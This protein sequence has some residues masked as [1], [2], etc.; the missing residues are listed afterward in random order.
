MIDLKAALSSFSKVEQR[1]IAYFLSR[2]FKGSPYLE[3]DGK[4]I[5][6]DVFDEPVELHI[7]KATE[8]TIKAIEADV[9]SAT[10]FDEATAQL[11]LDYV[12]EFEDSLAEQPT[13][14]ERS[15][16]DSFLKSAIPPEFRR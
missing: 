9:G 3:Q 16:A 6:L 10:A 15:E 1:E 4:D 8:S 5:F 7:R 2:Y 14:S 11:V 13:E 12:T